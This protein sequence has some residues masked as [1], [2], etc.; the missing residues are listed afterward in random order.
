MKRSVSL[1]TVIIFCLFLAGFAAAFLLTPA[2]GF[3]GQENRELAQAPELTASGLFSGKFAS[4]ANEYIADQFPARD[5]LVKLKSAAEL[6]LLKRAN[7]GVLYTQ[8]QLAVLEF[9]AYCSRLKTTRNA[10]GFYA[11]SVEARAKSYSGRIKETG[12]PA[13]T[14]V[15]PRTIDVAGKTFGCPGHGD[16]LFALLKQ[17]FTP[18]AGFINLLPDMRA[19]YEAGEYIIYRTDHHWTTYGA[20]EAYVRIMNALGAGENIIAKDEF[21]VEKVD[22]FSGTTAARANFPCCPRDV[23]EIWTLPDEG[24]YTV[25]ADGADIGGFYN[26]ER[27]EPSDKYSVFL[28]GT[29]GVTAVTKKSGEARKTLLVIKDSFANCLIPF[30]SREFDIVAL[31][32]SSAAQLKS[33]VEQYSPDALLTVCNAENIV[34]NGALN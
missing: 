10:D 17:S 22:G 2:R 18:E 4:E 9:D 25:I 6:A 3:S 33:A 19:A 7:N 23:L 29:H 14:L 16:D 8:N 27:L 34:S 5:E 24:D 13:V 12:L 31:D 26:R 20:Y 15:P 30:L 1:A 21:S 32:I 28:D 11:N